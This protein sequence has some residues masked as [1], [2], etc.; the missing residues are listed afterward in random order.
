MIRRND[1][2]AAFSWLDRAYENHEASISVIKG[3]PELRVLRS[4][5]RFTALLH[6]MNLPE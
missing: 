6:K 1:K 4:D 2:D 3:I 5:P